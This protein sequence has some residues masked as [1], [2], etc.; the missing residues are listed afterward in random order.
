MT[1]SINKTSG[2]KLDDLGDN[3]LLVIGDSANGITLFG[4]N[5]AN[6]GEQL[7]ENFLRLLEN[8]AKAT[9]PSTP[10]GQNPIIGQ[11]WWDTANNTLKIR[12]TATSWK[13]VGTPVYSTSAPTTASPGDLWYD[14]NIGSKQLKIYT[15]STWQVVG[16]Q[17]VTGQGATGF[18]VDSVTDAISSTVYMIVKINVNNDD[19][20]IFCNATINL[21]V[22]VLAS[23]PRI[24][25]PG[26]NLRAAS[27]NGGINTA[28]LRISSSGI[29]PNDNGVQNIGATNLRFNNIYGTNL[30][31]N[32]ANITNV[33]AS[34]A[35]TASTATNATNVAVTVNATSPEKYVTFVNAT[36]GSTGVLVN[37]NLKFDPSTNTLKSPQ[38]ETTG[39]ITV[40]ATGTVP[41]FVVSSTAPVANLRVAK[42]DQWSTTRTISLSG[43]VTSNAVNIDGSGNITIATTLGAVTIGATALSGINYVSTLSQGTGVSISGTAGPGWTP[44]ISI[45]QAVSTSNNVQFAS[46]GIGT[47]PVGA[48]EIRT[49]GDIIAFVSSD[50]TLKENI[51]PIQHALDIVNQ[52]RGVKFDWKQD[53]IN[54]RGGEDG[55][56]VRK[57]D[58]GIIAQ[59]VEQVLPEIV[60]RKASGTLG[61][62]YDKLVSV[63]IEA[64]KELDIKIKNLESRL[65]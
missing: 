18:T 55:Y 37:S 26:L 40:T 30:Y 36:T 42:A 5:T 65:K 53:Y 4:K 19:V 2:D 15:G 29:V 33:S 38:I 3:E 62:R 25:Y 52:L 58:I 56:F 6:Y 59:D 45:G 64:V 8:F 27:E 12:T 41:P 9:E 63:L 28:N 23:F 21:A 43:A 50:A 13:P 11:L 61:V 20:A 34:S 60:A 24:L 16:P 51:N 54:D 17:S 1:Y 32:G 14:N 49:T 57:K 31:G 46:L 10:I 35:S 7:N 39:S 47:S 48:G 22:D 44:T